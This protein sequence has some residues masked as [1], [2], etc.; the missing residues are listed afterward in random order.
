MKLDQ[1]FRTH[2][3]NKCGI[4]HSKNFKTCPRCGEENN[5][6]VEANNRNPLMNLDVYRGLIILAIFYLISE[7]I[8]KYVIAELYNAIWPT[9]INDPAGFA[10]TVTLSYQILIIICMGLLLWDHLKVVFSSFKTKKAYIAGV[11][12]GICLIIINF[13]ISLIM[14]SIAGTATNQNEAAVETVISAYPA[15]AII[16]TA[17]LA[18]VAEELVFR[19][20]GMAVG[21]KFGNP[22]V[23]K[24]IAYAI[25]SILFALIHL[26]LKS[27]DL[28]TEMASFPV[29]FAMGLT[30]SF[31]YH[32]YGLAASIVAHAVNNFV[33]TI[34]QMISELTQ[35]GS[36]FC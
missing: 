20:G 3:C 6:Y 9:F 31:M 16:C 27:G 29:Y 2:K 7:V 35:S 21:D 8:S 1:I 23:R 25:S 33:P 18:P 26:N 30:L 5:D 36:I 22:V 32:R 14:K 34:I 24:I 15:I 28:V 17:I 12:G 10:L 19:V 4:Y 13:A 11:I